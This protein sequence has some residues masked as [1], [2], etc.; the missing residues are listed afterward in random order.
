VGADGGLGGAAGFGFGGS[1]GFG[2]GGSGGSGGGGGSGGAGGV[3]GS[4]GSGTGGT[5]GV[6]GAGGS[7]GV[8]CADA[9]P[10]MGGFEYTAG[11]V[12]KNGQPV[13]RYECRPF[14]NEGWC[15]FAAY[16]PGK[17]GAPWMDAWTDL[18]PCQ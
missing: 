15:R 14:P 3:G 13:H 18:G 8:S 10:W 17:Q 6:G 9:Q 7:G 11:K 12:V 1:G 5:G 4:G 2:F 16:E